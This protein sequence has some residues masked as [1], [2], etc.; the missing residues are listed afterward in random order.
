MNC[1]LDMAIS[2]EEV[3]GLVF[4]MQP[5]KVLGPDEMNPL[6]FQKFWNIVEEDIPNAIKNFQAT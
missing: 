3:Q 1:M 5:S 6:F 4:Q 2:Y